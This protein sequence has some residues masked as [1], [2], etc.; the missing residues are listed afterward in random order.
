[1]MTEA[2][3]KRQTQQYYEAVNRQLER[4]MDELK[5]APAPKLIEAMRYSLLGGG[6]RIRPILLLA[7]WELVGSNT[8]DSGVS[9]AVKD[10]GTVLELAQSLE[11]IHTYSLIHDDLPAMDDYEL[12]RGRPT[13]HIAFDEATAILAGDA[14]L[15]L[16]YEKMFRVCAQCGENGLKASTIIAKKS[17]SLGMIAGQQLDLDAEREEETDNYPVEQLQ[18]LQEL[19]TSALIEAAVLAGAS[20][21][22]ADD[23]LLQALIIFS[24]NLGLTFQI[25]DDLLDVEATAGEIGKTPGKDEAAGK[26]TYVTLLGAVEARRY[27]E[28]SSTRAKEVLSELSRTGYATEYLEALTEFLLVRSS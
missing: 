19:K 28:R 16:A 18:K 15:N 8:T 3:F 11:M 2:E 10:H 23:S 9:T 21:R 14:L 13:N 25:R 22:G 7:T 6:K 1:M 4:A 20:L 17:G 26:I 27:M 12:R 5:E 24:R